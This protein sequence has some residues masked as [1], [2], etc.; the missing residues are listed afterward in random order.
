M[1]K[2]L[3]PV[4]VQLDLFRQL[5]TYET[6]LKPEF[7]L[8]IDRFHRGALFVYVVKN[9]TANIPAGCNT[10]TFEP[11]LKTEKELDEAMATFWQEV[12][13]KFKKESQQ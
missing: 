2:T 1:S 8:R 4:E 9:G 6:L 5:L 11:T 10:W 7:R 3:Y 12:P 13:Q